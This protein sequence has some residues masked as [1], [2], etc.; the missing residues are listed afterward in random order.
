M[1]DDFGNC[2]CPPGSAL[3]ENGNCA[4]CSSEK[5]L[6]IDER[7]HCVCNL[8]RGMII[9]ERGNCICPIEYGYRI[10]AKGNCI[11]E[12]EPECH[13]DDDCPDNRYCNK[14]IEMCEDP[15]NLKRCGVN[16]FCNATNHIAVCQ[17]ISGHTGN[18][19]VYCSK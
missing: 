12:N 16:T 5:G 3:N 10:D 15:C 19:E 14:E 13:T 7:G 18:P 8:E 1:L 6:K 17:C 2:V 4:L 9:D 11:R